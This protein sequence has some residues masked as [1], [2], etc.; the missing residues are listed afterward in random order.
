MVRFRART[1]NTQGQPLTRQAVR[2]VIDEV[3]RPGHFFVDPSIHIEWTDWFTEEIPWELFHGR[4]LDP[5]H[6]RLIGRFES[7]HV[8]RSGPDGRAAEP[9]IA[10]LYD[11][12][13]ENV[14]ITRAIDSMVTEG[15]EATDNTFLTRETRK[16]VRELVGTI[17]LPSLTDAEDL[18]DELIGYLFHA[19]VGASRLPL[20]SIEAPLPEFSFGQLAYCFCITRSAQPP[21][22]EYSEL[23]RE[24]WAVDLSRV[25]RIK[26]LEIAL[27]STPQSEVANLAAMFVEKLIALES[28]PALPR[29]LRDMFDYA[30][31]TPYTDFVPKTLDF[32]A[33]LESC[34]GWSVAQ[35]IDFLSYILRQL[36]RH[37]TAYDLVTYHQRGANY[38]DA[39]L[40]DEAVKAYLQLIEQ[41][42]LLFL[43]R[44]EDDTT[45]RDRK[46]IRRRALLHGWYFRRLYEGLA[47]PDEPTSAGENTRVLPPPHRR[48]PDVQILDTTTRT[49]HLFENDP[50]PSYLSET[51]SAV[52]RQS[53]IDL[54]VL[55]ELREL[56]SAIFL[57][58]PL[59]TCKR[60]GEPDRTPLLSYESF[61]R[62]IARRRLAELA[63]FPE[64][65]LPK[66]THSHAQAVVNQMP[67]DGVQVTPPST[68]ARPGQVSLADAY[69]VATDFVLLRMTTRSQREFMS[70]FDW[71]ELKER[72]AFGPAA[73]GLLVLAGD[74]PGELVIHWDGFRKKVEL[75]FDPTA[76]YR[77]RGGVE[78]PASGLHAVRFSEG[79][80]AHWREHVIDIRSPVMGYD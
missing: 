25:E 1:G 24:A 54:A 36:G 63:E 45:A 65:D 68:S 75:R 71:T 53:V 34:G 58:R 26:L 31:L 19:V 50:L 55:D 74:F 35:H 46:R 80:D 3:L 62:S 59:G 49:K 57:D 28:L 12:A 11:A 48:V 29:L 33:S 60:I 32:V 79:H 61:S 76:G 22:R 17:H 21:F 37:L 6:T 47:V 73:T 51:T 13:H 69:R 56:G 9:L 52:L 40:L 14:H 70:M 10:V 64:F 15:Y 39:L 72:V 38:P 27:R 44:D 8:Y 23:I 77:C 4:L 18:R 42:P 41:N 43:P 66:E 20:T 2:Q 7:R 67:M 78:Y 16:W 5:A 30:S